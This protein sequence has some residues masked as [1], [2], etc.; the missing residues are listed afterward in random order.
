MNFHGGDIYRLNQEVLD[1]SVNINPLGM[2]DMLQAAL[3]ENMDCF[4]RYPDVQY[5]SLR[6]KIAENIGYLKEQVLP[7]NG[8]ADVIY[9]IIG[10]VPVNRVV[11]ASPAFLEYEKAA[12]VFGKSVTNLS[13]YDMEKKKPNIQAIQNGLQPESLLVLCNPNNPMGS[14]IEKEVI[15]ECCAAMAK[16]KGF[17]LVDEA[18]MDFV[19]DK[20][21]YSVCSSIEKYPN[22]MVIGAATKYFGIPGIRLGWGVTS[23]TDLLQKISQSMEPWNINA[24][25]VL[26]AETIWEDKEYI[27]RTKAWL[28]KEK[29][30]VESQLADLKEIELFPSVCNF[31][32]LCWKK[33]T[34]L[35]KRLLD[36]GILIRDNRGFWSLPSQFY[37]FGLKG[38]EENMQF[39]EALKAVS[40]E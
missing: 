21:V 28:R 10:N 15:E 16:I 18:F 17:V 4:C 22:L 1:F 24:A 9:R 34:D 31:Y 3:R 7:G 20:Q 14:I 33:G 40:E 32:T 19:E 30:F 36:K 23:Y 39:I 26:A 38:R 27:T 8:A 12:A 5:E 35:K 6:Q 25:A 2:P 11:I 29:S 13:A 37:R